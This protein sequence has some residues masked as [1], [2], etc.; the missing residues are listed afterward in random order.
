MTTDL[1]GTELTAPE[2]ALLGAYDTLRAL[3]ADDDLAPCA[4]AGVRAALAHLGVVVTDLGLRF[5]HLLD[6]GV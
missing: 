2:T 5:E 6:D 1:L 4:A 3:A